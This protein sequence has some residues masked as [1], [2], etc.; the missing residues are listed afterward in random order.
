MIYNVDFDSAPLTPG[1]SRTMRINSSTPLT[2]EIKCFVRSPPPPG[3]KPCAAC[4]SFSRESGENFVIVADQRLFRS[5]AGELEIYIKD[6]TGDSR[7]ISIPVTRR[8]P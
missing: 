5:F 1:E 3:F 4:G 2:V 6:E 8:L 7:Q